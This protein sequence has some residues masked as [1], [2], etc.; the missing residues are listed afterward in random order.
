MDVE[1]VRLVESLDLAA[2]LVALTSLLDLSV[3]TLVTGMFNN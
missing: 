2:V 1:S 3:V